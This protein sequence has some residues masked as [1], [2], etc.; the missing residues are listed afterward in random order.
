DYVID[1]VIDLS[2]EVIY[3]LNFIVFLFLNR[4]VL[5]N[6]FLISIHLVI[7]VSSNVPP[8]LDPS[9]FHLNDRL[10]EESIRWF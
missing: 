10:R 6:K 2:A 7:I 8:Q 1:H 9:S 4:F 5:I 3:K